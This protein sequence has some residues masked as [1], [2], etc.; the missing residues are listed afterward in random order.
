MLDF[1]RFYAKKEEM[2]FLGKLEELI[3]QEQQLKHRIQ[4]EKNKLNAVAR[5]RQ[6]GKLIAWGI[7]IETM[8]NDPEEAM[9]PE[10]WANQCKR[11]LTD[12]RT[13]SPTLVDE[14]EGFK[15]NEIPN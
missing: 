3:K 15:L 6:D 5:K 4:L 7:V 11:F 2:G 12:K 9:T 10:Q 1:R 8:L 13:L 14:L